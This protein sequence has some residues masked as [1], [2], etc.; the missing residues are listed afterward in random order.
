V[1]ALLAVMFDVFVDTFSVIIERFAMGITRN[2]VVTFEH[3]MLDT[4]VILKLLFPG[5]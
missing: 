2:T 1:R 5:K 3:S 4:D